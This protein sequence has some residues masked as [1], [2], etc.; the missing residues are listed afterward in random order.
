MTR[1]GGG[2]TKIPCSAV[3]PIGMNYKFKPQRNIKGVYVRLWPELV[4]QSNSINLPM[5]QKGILQT[6]E[7]LQLSGNWQLATSW[8]VADFITGRSKRQ[9]VNIINIYWLALLFWNE[10]ILDGLLLS[11]TSMF[12]MIT[13][14]KE[15]QITSPLHEPRS[16]IILT[17][18]KSQ[19]TTT[20]PNRSAVK[21]C[22][23]I[24]VIVLK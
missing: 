14:V 9:N 1:C 3:F 6:S 18:E 8:N 15:A 7:S 4:L 16:L 2:D 21:I 22:V 13:G 19:Y 20:S 17:I 10:N 12:L 5:T 24:E 23:P 11:V